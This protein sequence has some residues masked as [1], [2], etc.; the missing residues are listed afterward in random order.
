M[1]HNSPLR[2]ASR[3]LPAN[4]RSCLISDSFLNSRRLSRMSK[5]NASCIARTPREILSKTFSQAQLGGKLK[6]NNFAKCEYEISVGR[7]DPE[8][9]LFN[10]LLLYLK[11]TLA[12]EFSNIHCTALKYLTALKYPLSP[13]KISLSPEHRTSV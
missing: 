12:S 9:C 10:K 6:C 4:R 7:S 5:T 11:T 13:F 8:F 3:A 2:H 1:C